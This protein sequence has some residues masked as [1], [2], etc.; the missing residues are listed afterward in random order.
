MGELQNLIEMLSKKP[1]KRPIIT[2]YLLI[3]LKKIKKYID[4]NRSILFP[5]RKRITK[6][7]KIEH[8]KKTYI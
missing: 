4:S 3:L 7:G 2:G 6:I 1:S 5:Q 8:S